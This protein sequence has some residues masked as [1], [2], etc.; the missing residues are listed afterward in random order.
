MRTVFDIGMY[1]GADTKY[2]LESGFRVIAVEANRDLIAS[3]QKKFASYLSAGQL[4]CVNK[5]VTVS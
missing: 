3:A 2:Y 4:V 5:A 1:D